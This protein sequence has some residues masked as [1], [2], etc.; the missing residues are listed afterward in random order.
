MD[1]CKTGG[2]SW[3]HPYQSLPSWDQALQRQGAFVQCQQGENREAGQLAKGS[4]GLAA[5]LERI[6]VP[7]FSHE[8]VRP[9]LCRGRGRLMMRACLLMMKMWL[10]LWGQGQERAAGGQHNVACISSPG[11]ANS[12]QCTAET[13]RQAPRLAHTLPPFVDTQATHAPWHWGAHLRG[14]PSAIARGGRA[15]RPPQ[16]PKQSGASWGRVQDGAMNDL[17]GWGVGIG[18]GRLPLLHALPGKHVHPGSA[19]F[20]PGT[21]LQCYGN[22]LAQPA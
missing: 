2:T 17:F 12:E 13:D 7:G 3:L 9:V 20:A 15:K 1:Q 4:K 11:T 18:G 22:A 10:G 21:E 8:G 16:T 14:S 19:G 6:S 5:L